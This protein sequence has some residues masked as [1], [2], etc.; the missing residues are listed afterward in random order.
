MYNI[1]GMTNRKLKF[2]SAILG[3]VVLGCAVPWVRLA[4]TCMSTITVILS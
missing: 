3:T 4:F 1:Q 2:G